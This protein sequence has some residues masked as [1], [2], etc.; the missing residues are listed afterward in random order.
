M[1]GLALL[2]SLSLLL[3]QS[4]LPAAA[5]EVYRKVEADGTVVLTDHPVPGSELI[6]IQPL[7]TPPEQ[8]K[9]APAR[10]RTAPASQGARAAAIPAY[11]SI[12]ITAPS[13]DSTF[14]Q[15]AGLVIVSVALNPALRADD[16]I[17]LYLDGK[18]RLR[19]SGPGFQ[20]EAVDRGLHTLR[21]SLVNTQ[22]KELLSSESVRFTL[23]RY[24]ALLQRNNNLS[25]PPRPPTSLRIRRG[26]R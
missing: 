23:L 5:V 25:R 4:L 22:G 24:S 21:A 13:P 6:E 17:V 10:A 18:E 1:K 12:Q 7:P 9:P 14:R 20:L 26:S 16:K 2:G 19:G 11:D 3:A 8:N 15:N